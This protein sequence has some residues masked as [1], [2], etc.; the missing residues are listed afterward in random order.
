MSSTVSLGTVRYW[1]AAAG[2]SCRSRLDGL[3][4]CR[5]CGADVELWSHTERWDHDGRHAAY[6]SARNRCCGMSIER[7]IPERRAS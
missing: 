5:T 1:S 3:H 6:G 2:R 4:R 7:I